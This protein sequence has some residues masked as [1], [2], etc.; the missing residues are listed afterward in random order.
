MKTIGKFGSL[1]CFGAMLG[2][3]ATLS[4]KLM[5]AACY[6]TQKS[7]KSHE[8]A[9]KVCAPTATTTDFAIRTTT[10]KVYKV[11]SSGNSALADDIRKGALKK[12]HDGDIHAT[13]NGSLKGDVVTVNSVNLDKLKQ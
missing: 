1:L 11:D 4:G 13:V 6:D 9:T 10:G 8:D 12:D 3:G 5:D 7:Q 2:Y